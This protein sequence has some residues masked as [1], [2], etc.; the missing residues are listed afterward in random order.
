MI[1]AKTEMLEMFR[2]WNFSKTAILF[3]QKKEKTTLTI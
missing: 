1:T 2:K 3:Q